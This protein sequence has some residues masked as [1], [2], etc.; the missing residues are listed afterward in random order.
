M[1]TDILE[2]HLLPN[3]NIFYGNDWILQQDNDPKHTAR[4]SKGW[5]QDTNVTVLQWPSYS[6]D[7]NPI[8]SV[9]G[10]MMESK[11]I[12]KDRRYEARSRP[13]LGQYD[14]RNPNL[15]GQKYAQQ[16]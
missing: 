1:Y 9:W 13:I 12:D 8:E 2:S 3:M 6:P 7:L 16:N 15:F 14:P 11:G 10:M 5:F 4:H